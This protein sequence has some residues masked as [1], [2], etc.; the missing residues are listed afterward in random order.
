MLRHSCVKVTDRIFAVRI[1]DLYKAMK[2]QDLGNN[3]RI[4]PCVKRADGH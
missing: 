3:G 1:H 4:R 2:L